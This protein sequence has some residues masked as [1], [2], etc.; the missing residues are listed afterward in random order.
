[1]TTTDKDSVV[2]LNDLTYFWATDGLPVFFED[3]EICE[4]KPGSVGGQTTAG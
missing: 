2:T 1:M 3:R 4:A